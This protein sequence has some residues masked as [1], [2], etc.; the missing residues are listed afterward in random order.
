[1]IAEM[2][3]YFS[4]EVVAVADVIFAYYLKLLI[5]NYSVGVRKDLDQQLES[6]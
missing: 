5:Q 2:R 3:S 1:M 4:D 6:N